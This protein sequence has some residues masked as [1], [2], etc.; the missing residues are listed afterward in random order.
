VT[1]RRLLVF[2]VA[3]TIVAGSLA[4]VPTGAAPRTGGAPPFEGVTTVALQHLGAT[5]PLAELSGLASATARTQRETPSA[6]L[7]R[8]RP[9]I[10]AGGQVETVGPPIPDPPSAPDDAAVSEQRPDLVRSW[11]GSNSF[12]QGWSNGGNAFFLEPPDQGLCVGPDHVVE[13]INSIVQIYTPNGRALLPGTS[14]I[15]GTE[16]V[17]ISHNE[18]FGFPPA[19]DIETGEFGPFTT[20][21]SCYYDRRLKRWFHAELTIQQDPATGDFTGENSIDIAVSRSADPTGSWDLYRLPVQNDG[22]DGT[23]DHGCDQGPCIGDYP[24]IGADKH[25]FYITTNEYS[26]FGDGYTGAQLYALPKAALAGGSA[27]EAV[28][29]ENLSVPSLDQPGFTVRPAWSRPSSWETGRG[30]TEYFVSSTAGD[31]SETGNPTGRSDDMVVWALTNTGSLAGTPDL[32]LHQAVVKTLVYQF[33]PLSLQREGPTPLLR[34]MNLGVDCLFGEDLG[35]Q[36]GPYPLD[37]GD[38][39]VTS[40]FLADGVLWSSLTTALTGLGGASYDNSDGSFEPVDQRAGVAYFAFRPRWDDHTLKARLLQDG[41]VAV[42]DANITY[43]SLAVNEHNEGYIGVSLVGPRYFP[44]AAYIP[45]ELG[46]DPDVVHIAARGRSP[47]DGFSGTVFGGF[48][49]RWQDY[50]YMVPGNGGDLWFGVEYIASRCR[51][52]RWLAD[53]N[54]GDRRTMFTNWSTRV[55]RLDT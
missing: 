32:H 28:L 48:R 29:F 17:G 54:C 4:A 44:S 14:G 8:L 10:G 51:F 53:T 41:Y 24:H 1:R 42:R 26:F 12:D 49:P 40:S 43:P 13:T 18:W 27:T 19:I 9:R 7:E 38:T 25:G 52:Q 6:A 11:E 22:S 39:R 23:P 36:P 50:G 37:S 35:Q 2:V 20:D 16:P 45:L 55:T 5:E 33:P 47:S 31:G 15:P 46:E 3:S 30:G 21:P 34:C